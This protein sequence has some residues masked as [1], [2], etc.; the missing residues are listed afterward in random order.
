V[1]KNIDVVRKAMVGSTTEGTAARVF[2]GAAYEVAGK[3]G[4]SQVFSLRGAQY[5][6]AAV[7]ENLHNH[8]LFIAF[9]PASE[10]KIALAVLVEN[11]GFGA[12]AAAP[13]ARIVMDYYLSGRL[14][15]KS[16]KK[17]DVES[18]EG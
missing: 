8:S 9:A 3:T 7:R 15:K 2:N 14:P 16:T 13:I 1:Q 12:R 5:D 11:A 6:A 10:P 4:T 17:E 18:R